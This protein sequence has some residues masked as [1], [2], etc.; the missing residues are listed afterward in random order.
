M[1][2]FIKLNRNLLVSDTFSNPVTLKVW[3]W[4]L[5]KAAWQN[6]TVSTPN[7]RGYIDV[8][9]QRGELIFGRKISSQ[10]LGLSE[11]ALYRQIQKLKDMGNIE[12]TPNT[13]YSIITICKYNSYNYNN[14][15]NE[16]PIR[17]PS[18]QP[19]V[20]PTVQPM[21]Q[22]TDTTKESKESKEEIQLV[23]QKIN[24]KKN[25][26]NNQQL[27]GNYSQGESIWFGGV[28]NFLS[29]DDES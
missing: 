21:I 2:N 8:K 23:K 6:K 1:S 9:I 24:F 25:E 10:D 28:G 20:Q 7:G 16:L 17:Q 15:K 14:E 13:H 27:N 12:I 4:L 18:I 26:K 19:T 11:S 5:L 29:K 22:Q 3:I